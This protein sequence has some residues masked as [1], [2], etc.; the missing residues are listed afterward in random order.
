MGCIETEV[1]KQLMMKSKKINFNMGCIE[2]GFNDSRENKKLGI[3]FNMGC[4]ETRRLKK[5][6]EYGL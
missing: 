4:I 6:M 3:N 1:L 2:T 5:S